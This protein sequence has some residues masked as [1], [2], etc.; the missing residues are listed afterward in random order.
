MIL[1]GR[2]L[3][4]GVVEGEAVVTR[5]PISF[6]GGVDINT[7]VVIEKGH[8]LE[9][10]SIKDKVLVFPLG[11]GT[12][13]NP[14]AIYAMKKRGSA[15]IAIV[16]EKVEDIVLTGCIIAEIPFVECKEAMKIKS[17]DFLRVDG[18]KGIIEILRR[19]D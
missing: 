9:G 16:N 19:R 5:K 1:R 18:G 3:V 17:G 12:T 7:G 15:P 8:E 13:Y 2:G 4:E 14:F 10:K 6:V 11:K